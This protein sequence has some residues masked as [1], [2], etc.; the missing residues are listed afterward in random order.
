MSDFD[1]WM[2]LPWSNDEDAPKKGDVIA[3][4]MI[5]EGS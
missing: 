1:G 3:V 5:G 2:K 4:E